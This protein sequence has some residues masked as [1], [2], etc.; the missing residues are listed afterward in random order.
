MPLSSPRL[1]RGR[2][3]RRP[4]LPAHKYDG[5]LIPAS[6]AA[7]PIGDRTFPPD[8]AREFR[9]NILDATDGRFDLAR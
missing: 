7:A 9:L 5:V 4:H 3:D 8:T 1:S 2:A 6:A